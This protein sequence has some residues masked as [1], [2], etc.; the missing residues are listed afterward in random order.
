MILV[1]IV[2]SENSLVPVSVTYDGTPMTRFNSQQVPSESNGA[3][4]IYYL[5]DSQLPA[6]T[7]N[8]PVVVQMANSNTWGMYFANVVELKGVHQ[9]NPFASTTSTGTHANAADCGGTV[10]RGVSTNFSAT[11][12]FVY[13]LMAARNANVGATISPTAATSI[14]S[15]RLT[16]P[17]TM[18]ALAGYLVANSNTTIS[19][20]MSGCWSTAGVG[21]AVR[22][23]SGG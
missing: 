23:A 5:L 22:R 19:W 18:V 6:A 21:V 7:G 2:A 20:T 1:G 14:M 11:G 12:S 8:K 13:T 3:A 17:S 15:L 9:S 4:H 16:S 10:S